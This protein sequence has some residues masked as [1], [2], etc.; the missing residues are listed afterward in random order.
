MITYL[1]KWES[2]PLSV[3]AAVAFILTLAGIA[4]FSRFLP[5][6]KGREFAVNGE[7]S[8][9]KSRGAGIILT[10]ALILASV[11]C[12]PLTLE[13]VIY[14]AALFVEMLSGYLDDASDKPWGELKKGMIDLVV[15]GGVSF[16]AYWFH[17]STVYLPTFGITFTI[18]MVLYIV[19]GIALI[20]GSINV[21][22]CAD[23]VDGLCASMSMV[24]LTGILAISMWMQK[25]EYSED[26]SMEKLS[27]ISHA[28]SLGIVDDFRVSIFIAMMIA[29]LLAYLWF[30]CSPSIMLMGDAGSR[31]LGLFL[32]IVFM[33]TGTPFLFVPMGLMLILD[34][35]LG[36]V[37][38]TVLRVTKSKTFMKNIRTPLHDHA[39]KNKGWSDT[40]VVTRFTL[41]Q[42]VLTVLT[43]G[44]CKIL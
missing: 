34:G 8:K 32:A 26:A 40:Q 43:L 2:C 41:M 4:S 23:G 44:I 3:A 37:K 19:L 16:T 42:I 18:P 25:F 14:L 33:A 31:A 12:L 11:I 15:A 38:L 29:V 5:K 13:Y 21:T 28:A 1:F 30:N 36:L 9:G 7:K 35:G 6:D 24:T 22:N 10:A 39:R 27:F 20:W 17:G